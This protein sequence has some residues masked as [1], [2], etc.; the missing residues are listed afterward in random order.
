[1]HLFIKVTTV[2]IMT[3][4]LAFRIYECIKR[5]GEVSSDIVSWTTPDFFRMFNAYNNVLF[6]ITLW[7]SIWKFRS[8]NKLF[9][10]AAQYKIIFK[11]STSNILYK[12]LIDMLPYCFWGF[13][14]STSLAMAIRSSSENQGIFKCAFDNTY[15]GLCIIAYYFRH[16][17]GSLEEF[18]IIIMILPLWICVNSFVKQVEINKWRLTKQTYL[19]IRQIT[20][21]VNEIIW[22]NVLIRTLQNFVFYAFNMDALLASPDLIRR[23]RILVFFVNACCFSYFGADISYKVNKYI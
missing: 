13:T 5:Q 20:D 18:I 9:V 6:N 1:M 22:P 21:S 7:R 12:F 3:I 16:L 8:F 11:T 23:L 15:M 19:I 4:S 10:I 2:L 17:A 14:I